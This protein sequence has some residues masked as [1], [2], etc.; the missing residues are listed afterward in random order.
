MATLTKDFVIEAL[1]SYLTRKDALVF[2]VTLEPET[3]D[4]RISALTELVE[5]GTEVQLDQQF[6]EETRRL[7]ARLR[8]IE[9]EHERSQRNLRAHR[10]LRG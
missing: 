3:A 5:L 1:A 6:L 10:K 4:I 2:D 7:I 8:G 9:R